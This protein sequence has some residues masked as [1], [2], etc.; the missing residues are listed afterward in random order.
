M[1]GRMTGKQLFLQKK[2]VDEIESEALVAN[3]VQGTGVEILII[4]LIFERDPQ[5]PI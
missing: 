5:N 4:F 1:K 2:A 3:Q